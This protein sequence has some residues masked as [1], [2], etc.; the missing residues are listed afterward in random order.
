MKYTNISNNVI[1]FLFVGTIFLI[2]M[3]LTLIY[4]EHMLWIYKS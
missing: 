2:K 1:I 3:V 4:S